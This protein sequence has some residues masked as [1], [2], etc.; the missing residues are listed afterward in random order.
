MVLAASVTDT[1]DTRASAILHTPPSWSTCA[2]QPRW[3]ARPSHDLLQDVLQCLVY[4]EAELQRLRDSDAPSSAPATSARAAEIPAEVQRDLAAAQVGGKK[5]LGHPC[6]LVQAMSVSNGAGISAGAAYCQAHG[7]N[8][9][10]TWFLRLVRQCKDVKTPAC[11]CAGIHCIPLRCSNVSVP[12][13]FTELCAGIAPILLLYC[14]S[15]CLS[16]YRAGLCW[17]AAASLSCHCAGSP[18]EVTLL[19][20]QCT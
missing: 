14:S 8:A 17:T 16:H 13:S 18:L 6:L 12:G 20:L 5:A 10:T 19:T 7:Q 2:K 1:E 15:L 11:H 3:P 9:G 4:P